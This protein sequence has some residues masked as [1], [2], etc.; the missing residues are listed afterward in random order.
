MDTLK[1]NLAKLEL[2][3]TQLT[4]RELEIITKIQ[5][6]YDSYEK[7]NR[8]L[9]KELRNNKFNKNLVSNQNICSR[10]TLYGNEIVSKYMQLLETQTMNVIDVNESKF[11]SKEKYDRVKAENTLLLAQAVDVAIKDGEIARLTH[12]NARLRRDIETLRNNQA[13]RRT[14]ERI[15]R[16]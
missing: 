11:V 9:K 2:D 14:V 16:H 6:L 1:K 4:R 10:Q 12:E 13:S 15:R 8:N 5:E 7:K 3:E